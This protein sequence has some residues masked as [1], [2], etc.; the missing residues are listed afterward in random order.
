[1]LTFNLL[2]AEL[3]ESPYLRSQPA[4]RMHLIRTRAECDRGRAVRRA[5]KTQVRTAAAAADGGEAEYLAAVLDPGHT[6]A[7][8]ARNCRSY[9]PPGG[10]DFG[11]TVNLPNSKDRLTFVKDAVADHQTRV[12]RHQRLHRVRDRNQGIGPRQ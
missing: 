12:A 11:A 8:T 5:A 4:L 9:W 1:M 3:Y 10:V 6:A 2:K 7:P